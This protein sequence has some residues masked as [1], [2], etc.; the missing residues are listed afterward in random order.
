MTATRSGYL[1]R[2]W[3]R[4]ARVRSWLGFENIW[5]G[6]PSSTSVAFAHEDDA[7]RDLL[8]KVDL[9]GDEDHGAA[10]FGEGADHLEHLPDQFRVEGGS[11]FVEE[12]QFRLH[13][14][15]ASDRDPLLLSARQAFRIGARLVGHA[16]LL[17]HVVR[18]L[19]GLLLAET[20]HPARCDGGVVQRREV[21]KQ[22]ETLK[23]EPYFGAL[24]CKLPV[25]EV[26]E[27]AVDLL[28]PNQRVVDVDVPRARFLEV[29]HAAQQGGLSGTARP[30]DGELF[31]PADVEIDAPEDLERSEAL[32]EV[33]NS[34]QWFHSGSF[35]R[36]LIES[37]PRLVRNAPALTTTTHSC[38]NAGERRSGR[39]FFF[40]RSPHATRPSLSAGS[41]ADRRSTPSSSAP[42][43]ETPS[44][45][46]GQPRFSG[47]D[48]A[49]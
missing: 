11:R 3:L 49:A 18:P 8:G 5:W 34:E 10:F 32:V 21:R 40:R 33:D 22:V 43:S 44:P 28:L 37:A 30:D 41:R 19:L 20:Q 14:Q 4:K 38:R 25:A 1:S 24:L 39:C 36:G 31:S 45:P 48:R 46:A 12:H 35:P 7:I 23:H 27:L 47:W 16:D 26:H 42:H 17:E 6:G 15:G 9:M 29:V 2:I 13:G